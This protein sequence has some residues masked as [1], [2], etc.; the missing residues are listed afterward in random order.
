M[1]KMELTGMTITSIALK[2]SEVFLLCFPFYL[3]SLPKE[4]SVKR[5]LWKIRMEIIHK[6]LLFP[7]GCFFSLILFLFLFS[8][9]RWVRLREPF[10]RYQQLAQKD[11]CRRAIS[12]LGSFKSSGSI[13][14]Q[15]Q[16]VRR[17]QWRLDLRMLPKKRHA[18]PWW[19]YFLKGFHMKILSTWEVHWRHLQTRSQR[20]L[21]SPSLA[22]GRSWRCRQESSLVWVPPRFHPHGP[23]EHK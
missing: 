6:L 10:Q 1:R 4:I 22:A 21:P 15:V 3:Q 5:R 16:K 11:V 2:I 7:N 19:T 20:L 14:S 8:C 17:N 23:K 18:Y 12:L 9:S 13:E